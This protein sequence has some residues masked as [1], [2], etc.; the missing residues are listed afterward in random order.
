MTRRRATER[1]DVHVL[2]GTREALARLVKEHGLS[3]GQI[4]DEAVA[5][6]LVRIADGHY[7]KHPGCFRESL[8]RVTMHGGAMSVA[9]FAKP[10]CTMH[11]PV[12]SA[13]AKVS[14]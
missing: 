2:E 6:L 14:P 3:T 4:L 11:V 9:E 7:C 10:Y 12:P 1:L 5:A 13:S 8:G